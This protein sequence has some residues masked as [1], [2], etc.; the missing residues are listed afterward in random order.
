[1]RNAIDRMK[2]MTSKITARSALLILCAV[3]FAVSAYMLISYYAQG[4]KEEQEFRKLADVVAAQRPPLSDSAH[5]PST[6]AETPISETSVLSAYRELHEQNP[7]MVGWVKIEGTAIN[8]P[9][10]YTP[11]D[12]DYYLNH[13]FDR[14]KAKSGV[15][16]I[17][18]RC[19]ID[20][21]GTNTIIY[22]HHMKNGTMFADLAK[23][24]SKKYW[25]EHP[26]VRFDTL[27]AQQEYEIIAVFQSKIYGSNEKVFKHYNF[28]NAHSQADF[29]RYMENI[30]ALSLYDTGV[31]AEY[32]DQLLSLVTCD[33]HDENGQMVVVARKKATVAE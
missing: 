26:K 32:G 29:D 11:N 27:S 28:I 15:P 31:T 2:S 8:Y 7:D 6:E 19:A 21:L 13:G 22:G 23:Y 30:K 10:M 24:K 12:G 9:V 16:F 4:A 3:V 14:K 17:D 25:E 5:T 20:P 33:Y 18:Q 1:M